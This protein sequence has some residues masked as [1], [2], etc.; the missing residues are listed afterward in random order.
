MQV[1]FLNFQI[2]VIVAIKLQVVK[3]LF[4]VLMNA[5]LLNNIQIVEKIKLPAC[6]YRLFDLDLDFLYDYELADV[7]DFLEDEGDPDELVPP[8]PPPLLFELEL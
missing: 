5:Y 8:T 7:F 2:K 4:M 1:E 6:L 3:V